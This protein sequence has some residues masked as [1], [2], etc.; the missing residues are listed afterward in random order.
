VETG[1]GEEKRK[2]KVVFFYVIM[3]FLFEIKG[4]V[5]ANGTCVCGAGIDSSLELLAI[6]GV[7]T[8]FTFLLV[9]L[10]L[11]STTVQNGMKH[12]YQ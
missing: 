10:F 5:S 11:T 3:L 7:P 1:K 2:K 12:K 8:F 6:I 4:C 9:V